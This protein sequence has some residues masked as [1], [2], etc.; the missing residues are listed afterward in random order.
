[1]RMVSE[2]WA[3]GVMLMAGAYA[4]P[5]RSRPV[6]GGVRAQ[7]DWVPAR[8]ACIDAKRDAHA[9]GGEHAQARKAAQC[10]G[11][12]A[13]SVRTQHEAVGFGG[14]SPAGKPRVIER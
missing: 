11:C 3:D 9:P 4:R 13:V 14:G 7:D 8:I 10:D 2:Y 6:G 12:L 1:M 5:D